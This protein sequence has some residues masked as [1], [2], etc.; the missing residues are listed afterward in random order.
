[1]LDSDSDSES[2][3]HTPP[4]SSTQY[5]SLPSS[6]NMA[7]ANA[8]TA[9]GAIP[10]TGRAQVALPPSQWENR[11]DYAE[12]RTQVFAGR[13]WFGVT[14]LPTVPEYVA[15]PAEHKARVITT[16]ALAESL[17]MPR[18]PEKEFLILCRMIA[19]TLLPRPRYATRDEAGH[20]MISW[21]KALL[22][23]AGASIAG[24]RLRVEDIV[25]AKAERGPLHGIDPEGQVSA[26]QAW[27]TVSWI[28]VHG[29]PDTASRSPAAAYA[30]TYISLAKKGTI[31][32]RKLNTII[33][34][35]AV[36]CNIDLAITTN[37]IAVL[38]N[39]LMTRIKQDEIG[40]IFET[41]SQYM[42]GTS[43]RMMITL[44]Q[45]AGSGLTSLTTIKKALTRFPSFKWGRVV[46]ILPDEAKAVEKAFQV[47]GADKY[48]GFR[49][50]YGAASSTL[51]RSFSWV[52]KEL[53]LKHGG[54]DF[55]SLRDYKGWA[56]KPLHQQALKELVDAFTPEVAPDTVQDT[57]FLTTAAEGAS[58]LI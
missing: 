30:A 24:M 44:N 43:L 2:I 10:R 8:S 40:T 48:Y 6:P 37:D 29:V 11:G 14:V 4:S 27:R 42:M 22:K 54:P 16:C 47:V 39:Q 52:A 3:Y 51:Y 20:C 58:G 46:S 9:A 33:G 18:E 55:D 50:D 34:A 32:A 15:L 26:D 19:E 57:G 45:A 56:T 36:E 31:T 17:I 38:Y 7:E 12:V 21:A 35:L 5:Y 23:H 1:M 13:D 25:A 49:R 41:W 28:A 53:L